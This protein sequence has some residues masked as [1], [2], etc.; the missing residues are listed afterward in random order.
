M[1]LMRLAES[2]T[3]AEAVAAAAQIPV[4]PILV[5]RDAGALSLMLADAGYPINN[6]VLPD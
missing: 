3:A 4:R 5:E 2:R 6:I 1:N